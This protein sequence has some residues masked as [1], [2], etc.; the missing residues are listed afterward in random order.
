[1]VIS[2]NIPAHSCTRRSMCPVGRG[3]SKST[4][5]NRRV[6]PR[7][8][9]AQLSPRTRRLLIVAMAVE[10]ALKVAAMIDLARRPPDEVRGPKKVWLVAIP[11]MNSLG[12]LP[13]VYFI[14]GRRGAHP[15]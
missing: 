10:S 6:I 4:D 7:R 13:I 9:W 15:G 2:G 8:R 5:Y 12:A 1:M 3:L 11:V 14:W